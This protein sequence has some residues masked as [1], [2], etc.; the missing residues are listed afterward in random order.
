M[1]TLCRV[2]RKRSKYLAKHPCQIKGVVRRARKPR[3]STPPIS[4]ILTLGVQDAVAVAR[5]AA[6][7]VFEFRGYGQVEPLAEAIHRIVRKGFERIV[8]VACDGSRGRSTR[9]T[10]VR[11]PLQLHRR[12]TPLPA[13][14]TT[15]NNKWRR[16]TRPAGVRLCTEHM[17]FGWKPGETANARV[18]GR[19][20]ALPSDRL[21]G[22]R[23]AR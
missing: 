18:P 11:S 16:N 10:A 12:P 9:S 7:G 17:R 3:P 23:T 4:T 2:L 15:W 20:R 6:F 13:V 19:S 21:S 22:Q 5:A 8:H 1:R 14:S